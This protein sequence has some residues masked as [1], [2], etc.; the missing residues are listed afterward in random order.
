MSN[1]NLTN[2]VSDNTFYNGTDLINI[3]NQKQILGFAYIFGFGANPAAFFPLINSITNLTTVYTPQTVS[4]GAGD[5]YIV[6]GG[7][8][9][10]GWNDGNQIIVYLMPNCGVQVWTDSG[11]SG[12]C[13]LEAYNNTASIV[14][15][16]SSGGSNSSI[17]MFIN[18]GGTF[19][20]NSGST[21][22]TQV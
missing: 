21:G 18:T 15:V 9:E 8:Y 6:K 3:I 19:T 4:S 10:N 14:S 11:Y 2:F 7:T 22:Y 12:S 5:L 16:E 1:T 17:A 20:G 13:Q